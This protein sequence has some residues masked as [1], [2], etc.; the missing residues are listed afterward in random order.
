MERGL[1]LGLA[2][3]ELLGRTA[4][5]LY[6]VPWL[7]DNTHAGFHALRAL[8]VIVQTAEILSLL[9]RRLNDNPHSFNLNCS[10][11]ILT[12]QRNAEDEFHDLSRL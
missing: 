5:H 1:P 6:D 2:S 9:Q 12:F 4:V 7:E 8:R 11:L 3:T 10:N